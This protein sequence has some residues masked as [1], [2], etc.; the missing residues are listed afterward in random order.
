M[1]IILFFKCVGVGVNMKLPSYWP[2]MALTVIMIRPS[3]IVIS[4]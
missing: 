3:Q 4:L 2:G 1:I